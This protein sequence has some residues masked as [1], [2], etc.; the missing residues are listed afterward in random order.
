MGKVGSTSIAR[1]MEQQHGQHSVHLHYVDAWH[2]NFPSVGVHY[3]RLL[4]HHG[5][6]SKGGWPKRIVCGVRDPVERV[7]SGYFQEAESRK[8]SEDAFRDLHAATKHLALR[9][10]SDLWYVCTWFWHGFFAGFD[11]YVQGFDVERG[12]VRGRAGAVEGFIYR[13]DR[14][15]E[16]ERAR[17]FSACSPLDGAAGE[18]FREKTVLRAVFADE[19]RC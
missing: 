13:Q 12:F 3:S 5:V 11:P 10:V 19:E 7:V 14:L 16:L 18:R 6:G 1:A 2:R 17:G 15:G 8:A 4:H 9:M